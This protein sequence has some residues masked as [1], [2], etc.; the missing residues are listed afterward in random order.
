MNYGSSLD[1][2][3]SRLIEQDFVRRVPRVPIMLP[4]FDS[5]D[6][7]DVALY[8]GCLIYTPDTDEFKG[9]D[10]VAWVDLGGGGGGSGTVT[11]VATGAG[12][13]GGAI[14]TSGTISLA[15]IANQRILANFSGGSA[16]PTATAPVSIVGVGSALAWTTARTLTLGTDAT[17]SV[18]FDGSADF[19][20]NLTIANN[21]VTYAKM[22][23][24]SAASR[25]VGRGAG[26]GSGDPQEI[27]LGAGLEMSGT[28]LRP[29][30]AGVAVVNFG[31]GGA[32]DASVAV[33]DASV[34]VSS[35]IL[36]SVLAMAS[37]D[38]TA[39]EHL[40]EELI[41][42]A[43]DIVAGVGF[44]IRARTGNVALRGSW[45]VAWHRMA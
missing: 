10:G 2:Q 11:S 4:R 32:S 23:D 13:T 40:A 34:G 22:Q 16:A 24:V 36:A 1:P 19:T 30:T 37:A 20:L 8:E 6:L 28:T 35:V 3:L 38:H 21:A 45:N 25:L 15:S 31:A 7:P 39:D 41:V 42:M 27:S 9:S 14:T 29:G 44:N 33:A 43:G 17:G 5:G 26:A 12:L 18:A